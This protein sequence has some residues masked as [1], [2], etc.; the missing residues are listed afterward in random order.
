MLKRNVSCNAM[1]HRRFVEPLLCC[2]ALAAGDG[3]AMV[4]RAGLPL[5]DLE[6]VQFHPTG[7]RQVAAVLASRSFRAI[8]RGV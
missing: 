7:R 6:F 5:Q 2:F 3:G 4:A 8:V 1:H